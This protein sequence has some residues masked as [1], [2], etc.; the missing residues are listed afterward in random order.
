MTV[1]TL[2]YSTTAELTHTEFIDYIAGKNQDTIPY[3]FI[4]EIYLLSPKKVYLVDI[5]GLQSG[6]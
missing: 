2:T 1:D 6:K 4:L 5:M 3:F